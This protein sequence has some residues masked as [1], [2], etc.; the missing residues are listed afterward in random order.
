MNDTEGLMVIYLMD[1]EAVFNSDE[2]KK[3]ATNENIDMKTPIIGFA[4]G[5]PPLQANIG[6]DYLI[7]RNIKIDEEDDEQEDFGDEFEGIE[8]D[9]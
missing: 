8:S 7:N 5:I 9:L 2:L 4:L 1:T 6:E 3:K